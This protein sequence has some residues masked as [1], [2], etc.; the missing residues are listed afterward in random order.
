MN[1]ISCLRKKHL[2]PDYNTLAFAGVI[3]RKLVQRQFRVE[4]MHRNFTWSS[5]EDLG[6]HS[7]FLA[8]HCNFNN[9]IQKS[10]TTHMTEEQMHNNDRW[11][12]PFE[13]PLMS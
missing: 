9:L 13:I 10:R 5:K 11:R 1:S 3:T 7:F 6:T 12:V 4:N 8:L 2:V